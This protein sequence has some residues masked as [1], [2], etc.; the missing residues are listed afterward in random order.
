M[1]LSSSGIFFCLTT[2]PVHSRLLIICSVITEAAKDTAYID[3]NM[4][5]V[6]NNNC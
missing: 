1:G 5:Q 2:P 6:K 3:T 4:K